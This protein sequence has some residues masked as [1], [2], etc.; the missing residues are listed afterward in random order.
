MINKEN[1]SNE[2][3]Q[4]LDKFVVTYV[5][6]NNKKILINQYQCSDFYKSYVSE[7]EFIVTLL[8]NNKIIG[9][10]LDVDIIKEVS[11]NRVELYINL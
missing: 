11:N 9:H 2:Y 5:M 7:D 10:I 3:E 1:I 6:L 4:K 8:Y